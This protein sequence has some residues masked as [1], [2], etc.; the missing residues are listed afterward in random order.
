MVIKP[1][2]KPMILKTQG[3]LLLIIL[4]PSKSDF[5]F[6]QELLPIEKQIQAFERI[7]TITCNKGKSVK[8]VTAI[9]PKCPTGYKKK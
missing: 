2:L 3:N 6:K 4:S 1:E 8:K 7:V 5:A 9:K